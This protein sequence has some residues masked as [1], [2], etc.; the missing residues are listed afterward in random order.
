MINKYLY[1][2]S[3]SQQKTAHSIKKLNFKKQPRDLQK[4]IV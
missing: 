1:L 2:V 3:C 4:V